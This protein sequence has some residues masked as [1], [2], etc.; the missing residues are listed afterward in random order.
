MA[1]TGNSLGKDYLFAGAIPW[2]LLTRHQS[3]V[4]V[5]GPSQTSLGS[6][7]WKELRK[8]VENSLVPLGATVSSGM[9]ASPQ[10]IT[11]ASGW[12]ALG[13]STTSVERASGQHN[14]KLLVGVMEASG[15]EDDIWDAVD[16][17]KYTRLFAYGNPIRA[18]GRF[19]ALIRQA[20]KDRRDGVPKHLAVNAIRVPST[21]SPHAHLD[22]S[23]WGLADKTWLQDCFRRYGRD[24]LWCRSHVFAEIPA[25]DSESL[26]PESWLDWSASQKRLLLG[27]GHPVH[28]TRRISCDLGEGVGRDSS[29][30][31]VRDDW[32]ILDVTVSGAMGLA[33]AAFTI[34]EKC[35]QWN[36]PH[37]KV[38]Y[39]KMGI[40]RDFPL[41]LARQGIVT[42]VGY[43]GEAKP[44]SSD[45]T[46][47]R[48]EAAWKLRLRLDPGGSMDHRSPHAVQPPFVIPPSHYW[49]QLREALR[50]LTYSLAGRQT[51][52][53]TKEDWSTV[54]GHSPDVADALI[55]SFAF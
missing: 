15:V 10:T 43:A 20:E 27:A 50:V 28:Q 54:V 6:I 40:G 48:T 47:L 9:K 30:I 4:I 8:A 26:I 45:F 16:S 31:M 53:M 21:E 22:E 42:A 41:H 11:L 18:E 25:V 23:P 32:G 14:R 49:P 33:G 44:I 36:V 29:C 46:N 34:A 2:W 12:Q 35:R 19:V 55:Q 38:S 51:K 37:T 39:D 7:T 24:S 17:L 1:Y 52:L 13:Y 3:L 5:T